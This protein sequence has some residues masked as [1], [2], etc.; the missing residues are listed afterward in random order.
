MTHIG[1]RLRITCPAGDLVDL[2]SDHL[3]LAARLA[4][5]DTE[6]WRELFPGDG[7]GYLSVNGPRDLVITVQPVELPDDYPDD[8]DEDGTC[9]CTCS[10]CS[11]CLA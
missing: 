7:M 8:E 10:N 11:G 5:L 6:G 4:G 1:I 2:D 3:H 9:T